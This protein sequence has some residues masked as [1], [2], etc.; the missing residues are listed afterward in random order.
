[1]TNTSLGTKAHGHHESADE[2]LSQIKFLQDAEKSALA[3]IEGAKKQ[4]AQIEA[5][6]REKA[7]E[8]D[9][10]AAERAVQAK[11]EVLARGREQTDKEVSDILG[12]AKKQAEKIKG[13][14]LNDRDVS[15]FSASLL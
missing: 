9:A 8:A 15:S 3:E 12:D 6:G 1:V 4:S 13:K 7:V 11:N 5:A 10:K 14:R 2:F